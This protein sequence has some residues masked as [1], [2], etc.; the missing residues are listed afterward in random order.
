MAFQ[1]ASLWAM[2]TQASS[3]GPVGLAQCAL[4]AY[5]IKL[6]QRSTLDRHRHMDLAEKRQKEAR[7]QHEETMTALNSLGGKG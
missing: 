6:M 1:H 2:S 3:T 5:G 7:Q 4:I